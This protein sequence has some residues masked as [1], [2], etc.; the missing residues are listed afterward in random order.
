MYGEALFLGKDSTEH[1]TKPIAGIRGNAGVLSRYVGI[2][3][4]VP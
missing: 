1:K 4:S 3:L 2:R